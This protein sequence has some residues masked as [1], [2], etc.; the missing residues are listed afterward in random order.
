MFRF[1]MFIDDNEGTN[2][3]NQFII[4]ELKVAEKSVFFEKAEEALQ[5]LEAI[6]KNKSEI[7]PDVIFLDINMPKINGWAFIEKYKEMSLQK[8]SPIIML[9]TSLSPRD[10]EK[11]KNNPL[12]YGFWQKPLEEEMVIALQKIWEKGVL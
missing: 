2:C 1:L 7:Y 4:G 8:V 9:S 3:Y 10:K 6:K 5:Y 11:V 12:V